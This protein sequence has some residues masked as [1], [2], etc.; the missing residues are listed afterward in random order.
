M[1]QRRMFT[2][3]D[4]TKALNEA[5][6]RM[7]KT[8][9]YLVGGCAMIFMGRKVATKDVD[10]VFGSTSDAKDFASSLQHAGFTQIR[11]HTRA[12]D[13]L[14]ASAILE[15]SRGIRFDVFDK[16]VCRALE[17]SEGMK[18]R[19]RRYRTFGNLDIFLLS[20]EDIFLFKGI[21]ERE[22]DLEDMRILAE[23]RLDWNTIE[24]ECLSQKDSGRWGYMLGT[25]LLELRARFGIDSP[26]IKALMEHADLDLLRRVFGTI[27]TEGEDTFKEISKMIMDRYRYSP[28]W[29]RHQLR[30][31]VK[32]GI[33]GVRKE[34]RRHIYYVR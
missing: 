2:E 8:S 10:I 1:R 30:M 20:P 21:T 14:D 26:V 31:L 15:D 18:S 11:K 17:V 4:L 22:A 33:I 28:S 29:T 6:S 16:R 32:N 5:G 27:I 9:A 3:E 23:T 12:Y 34:G 24:R 19:A 7:R 13:A 25:K